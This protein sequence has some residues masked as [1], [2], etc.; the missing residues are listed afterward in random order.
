MKYKETAKDLRRN[1][2]FEIHSVVNYKNYIYH[3]KKNINKY[4]SSNN[5]S[6][7]YSK[8]EIGLFKD[9]YGYKKIL[10][11]SK[12]IIDIRG[13]FIPDNRKVFRA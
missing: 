2:L 12:I 3:C 7:K 4:L 5:L 1:N 10:K 11:N 6:I 8:C 13:R 9:G